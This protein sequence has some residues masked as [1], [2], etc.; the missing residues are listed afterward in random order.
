MQIGRIHHSEN[1]Q[2]DDS[3]VV[4]VPDWTDVNDWAA[5]VD[6]A[7]TESMPR[8]VTAA[9]GMDA[10]AH[11]LEG[12]WSINHQPLCDVLAIEAA[13][14]IFS[15]LE[16]VCRDPHNAEG[17]SNM[18]YAALLAGMAFQLPKN[19]MVHACSYPLSQ[20]CHLAHGV[21]LRPGGC[22]KSNRRCDEQ[23]DES[24]AGIQEHPA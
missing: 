9:T 15:N 23:E 1:Q 19:A 16:P 14:L 5:V 18:A 13:R 11:C 21:D 10:L 4:T 22:R 7:L 2:F 6:P 3:A 17:R 12:Y 24:Q 8:S 20:R